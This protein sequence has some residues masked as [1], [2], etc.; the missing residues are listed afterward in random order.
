MPPRYRYPCTGPVDTHGFEHFVAEHLGPSRAN[1]RHFAAELG[2]RFAAPHLALVNSGSSANLAAALALAERVGPGAHALTAGFTFPTT[3]SSLL[4]AGFEV[5]VVD[6]EPGGFC[7]DPAAVRR[8]LKPN[9]RV[10]CVTHFL[11][12]P[13]ALEAVLE[14]ARERDLLVLQD[15][16][17]TM[18]LRIGGQPAHAHGTLTTWSFYHPHHL[19]AFGGGAVVCPDA[20]WLRLVES[21][22]HWGRECTCHYDPSACT[23][24]PGIHHNFHYT[25]QGHNLEL[26]ELNACFGRFQLRSWEAYEARRHEHYATLY[27]ALRDVPG[28]TVYRAPEGNGSPFVFPLTVHGGDAAPLAQRLMARGV[29]V[30]T[31][32]G[33]AITRQPA[34]RHVPH[35]G[36]EHCTRLADASLFVGI[37]QTLPPEDVE[38]VAR[39]V[40]EEARR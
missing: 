10:V 6:T 20:K 13:A 9:T 24:P 15:A 35:D 32:M 28:L 1:L 27:A 23:A 3:M 12:F 5:T 29:E 11:G 22:T 21:L 31:L 16:C 40:A 8:A 33:G 34:Y 26:S 7:I 17:E 30:R 39:I 38:A 19:S 2:T 25:R 14:L 4:T 37:H 36:V 18:D